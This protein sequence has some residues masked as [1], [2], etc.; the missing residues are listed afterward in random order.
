MQLLYSLF[1]VYKDN[2]SLQITVYLLEGDS[3]P[4]APVFQLGDEPG[5]RSI[6]QGAGQ[7]VVF[8]HAGYVQCLN[9]HLADGLRRDSGCGFV[10]CVVPDVPYPGV[11]RF[12]LLI[13]AL[14]P[15]AVAG[16][17]IS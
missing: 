15:V 8:H 13:L 16:L 1:N 12:S 4:S 7:T 14:S 17:A 10:M 3:V 11:D 6:G 9:D 2:T 5:Q